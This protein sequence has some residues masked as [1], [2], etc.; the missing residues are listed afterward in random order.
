MY[1]DVSS[2]GVPARKRSC[3]ATCVFELLQ[4]EFYLLFYYFFLEIVGIDDTCPIHTADADRR[5]ASRQRRRSAMWIE[6]KAIRANHESEQISRRQCTQCYEQRQLGYNQ[7]VTVIVTSMSLM[8]RLCSGKISDQ[9]L[10][11]RRFES[12][13]DRCRVLTIL[14]SQSHPAFYPPGVG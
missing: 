7:I 10:R 3:T 4:K 2:I 8:A 5:V 12:H 9:W 1:D 6:L 13:Q 14:D 11:G